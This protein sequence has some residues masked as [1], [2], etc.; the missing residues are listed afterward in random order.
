MTPDCFPMVPVQIRVHLEIIMCHVEIRDPDF[1][2]NDFAIQK[3]PLGSTDAWH[4]VLISQG[5]TFVSDSI[6]RCDKPRTHARICIF[7][8]K[9]DTWALGQ[10]GGPWAPGGECFAPLL[11]FT[12]EAQTAYLST[13]CVST[14]FSLQ[15][16]WFGVRKRS[17]IKKSEFLKIARDHSRMHLKTF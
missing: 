8:L 5:D 17:R 10:S 6:W 7:F 11:C 12:H 14:R 9:C 1:L 13:L 2:K 16:W 15:N 4:V 3:L